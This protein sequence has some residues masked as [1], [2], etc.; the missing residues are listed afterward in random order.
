M[1]IRRKQK[2]RR[3]ERTYHG[4]HKKWR[5]G[6]SRGGRGQAGGHKHMYSY[7]MKYDPEHFGKRGFKR[8][9]SVLKN[10][11]IINLD[12]LSKMIPQ[13]LDKKIAEKSEGKIKINL[14]KA[15]YQKL[16]G[17]GKV[18]EPLLVEARYFSKIATKKIEEAGG[19]IVKV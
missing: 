15:G 17:R 8:P 3:G 14:T 1:V 7:L 9:Q 11:K 2:I 19:K 16:L 6:G 4:S 12:E 5:G 13:L 18:S 10:L